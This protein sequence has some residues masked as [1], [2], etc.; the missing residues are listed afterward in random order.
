MRA[1]DDSHREAA[2]SSSL[3]Q[4]IVGNYNAM[5][6]L[7]VHGWLL[8]PYAMSGELLPCMTSLS[9]EPA[10]GA[11]RLRGDWRLAGSGFLSWNA[12]ISCR[13]NRRT[14]IPGQSGGKTATGATRGTITADAHSIP[15]ST[16][17]LALARDGYRVGLVAR[18]TERLVELR[19]EIGEHAVAQSADVA[20]PNSSGR[21]SLR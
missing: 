16:I 10:L 20:N 3:G 7:T 18:R 4:C 1:N 17:A 21:R 8:P 9:W 11:E 19:D 12:A 5:L 6:R 14:G 2:R 15:M 13:K